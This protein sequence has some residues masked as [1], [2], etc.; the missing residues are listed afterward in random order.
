M[1][2]TYKKNSGITRT[3]ITVQTT[4][5]HIGKKIGESSKLIPIN[6]C[7]ILYELTTKSVLKGM[8][9]CIKV[10]YQFTFSVNFVP[11]R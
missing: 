5:P 10:G 2:L 9:E 6:L 4:Q 3:K 8:L 1:V 7:F 11:K